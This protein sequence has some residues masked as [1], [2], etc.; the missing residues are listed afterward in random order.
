MA[1]IRP[2]HAWR[3][4]MRRALPTALLPGLYAAAAWAARQDAGI[5]V[6]VDG[7]RPVTPTPAELAQLPGITEGVAFATE[8]GPLQSRF[9]GPLLWSVLDRVHAIPTGK[10]GEQRTGR[11]LS[12]RQR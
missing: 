9:E 7:G 11:W 3:R 6:S 5:A 10:A 4:L 12:C 8:H 2:L 1:T